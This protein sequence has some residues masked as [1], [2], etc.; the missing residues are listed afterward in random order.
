MRHL[1]I[2]AVIVSLVM[3]LSLSTIGLAAIQLLRSKATVDS[4]EQVATYMVID[5]NLFASLPRL[6]VER[7]YGLTAIMKE[8]DV[9][10]RHRQLSLGARDPFNAAIDIALDNLSAVRDPSLRGKGAEL[11]SL[12]AD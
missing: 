1:S 2:R 10:R 12:V 5:R 8:P 3:L 6:R 11:A 7:G 4:A 9:N